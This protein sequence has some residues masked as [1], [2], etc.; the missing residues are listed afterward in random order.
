VQENRDGLTV[1]TFGLA[2]SQAMVAKM[3]PASVLRRLVSS[4]MDTYRKLLL[5]APLFG[6]IAVRDRYDQEQSLRAGRIWQRAHLFATARGVA[7]RPAS[8]TVEMVDHE[9]STGQEARHAALL[10]E[11]T[12]DTAWEPTFMF[13]MGYAVRPG[14][15]SPRRPVEMV[16]RH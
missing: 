7:G 6:L 9:R 10:A 8:E 14:L 16:V 4:A 3:I 15:A 5:T 11:L 2:S 12:G 1:D 13:Y